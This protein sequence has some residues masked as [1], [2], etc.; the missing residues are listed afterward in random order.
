[1]IESRD[2]EPKISV[3][4]PAAGAGRRMKSYGPKSL[5]KVGKSTIVSNQIQ[6]INS[7]IPGAEIILI[8]GFK[9]EK[10]MNETPSSI[11]KIENELYEETNVIRSI[12]RSLSATG[13]S[14]IVMI[15]YGDLVFNEEMLKCVDMAESSVVMDSGTMSDNEVGC[16]VNDEGYLESIMYDLPEKWA[17]VLVLRG[18]ELKAFKALCWDKRNYKKFG[19]EMINE[20]IKKGGQFRA[21]RNDKIKVVDIDS[22]KDISRAKEILL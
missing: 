8:C 15:I 11:V 18:K 14:E 22:S 20:V 6:L 7:Q 2:R 9:S 13:K 1:M 17:Q 3:I 12:G 21:L 5:I 19:F 4:I 10:L 16:I